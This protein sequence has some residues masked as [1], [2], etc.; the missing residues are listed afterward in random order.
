MLEKLI[1]GYVRR[2]GDGE[3]GGP[4][5]SECLYYLTRL[6]AGENFIDI[7]YI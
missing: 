5:T 2:P 1:T 6:I 4:E 7:K 3:R